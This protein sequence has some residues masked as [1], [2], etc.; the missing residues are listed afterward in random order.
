MRVCVDLV[1]MLRIKKLGD[2]CVGGGCLYTYQMC[3]HVY[4]R[5]ERGRV[6]ENRKLKQSNFGFI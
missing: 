3:L 4:V 1:L 2:E 6:G 5:E